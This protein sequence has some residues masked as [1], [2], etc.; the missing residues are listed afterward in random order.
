M[1]SEA[2]TWDSNS[3]K[4]QRANEVSAIVFLWFKSQ[5]HRI[6]LASKT[7]SDEFVN[8]DLKPASRS[9]G[10]TER[11]EAACPER[12]ASVQIPID[13]LR[14]SIDVRLVIPGELPAPPFCSEQTCEEQMVH[15]DLSP[16]SRSANEVSDR[17]GPV[18]IPIDSL[19]SSIDVRLVIS[20]CAHGFFIHLTG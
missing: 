18:Q 4:S 15:L 16:T 7:A 12:L 1:T 2:E 6:F 20:C 14:S 8:W 11:R 3:W 10:T 5:P 19:R 13:S 17:L 9:P